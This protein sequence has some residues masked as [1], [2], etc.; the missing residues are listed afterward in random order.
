MLDSLKNMLLDFPEETNVFVG[1]DIRTHLFNSKQN[2]QVHNILNCS[3]N[4]ITRHSFQPLKSDNFIIEFCL[5]NNILLVSILANY[6]HL[7]EKIN[8]L[9]HEQN[10]PYFLTLIRPDLL[11]SYD[12]INWEKTAV[13]GGTFHAFHKGHTE[14]IDLAFRS[15]DKVNLLVTSDEM[16]K[17]CKP[18]KVKPFNDRREQ[19]QNFLIKNNYFHRSNI[20]EINSDQEIIEFC[21]NNDISLSVVIPEYYSLFERINRLRECQGLPGLLILVKQRTLNNNGFDIN[22]TIEDRFSTDEN[23]SRLKAIWEN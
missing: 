22:S 4:H 23:V 18:Y 20:K 21:L 14:Y 19:L 10:L 17:I 6:Y 15:A 13:I 12:K 8:K 11:G 3:L 1:N 9:R 7:F 16:A 2:Y 5:R